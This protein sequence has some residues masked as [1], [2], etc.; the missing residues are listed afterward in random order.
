MSEP[1]DHNERAQQA[2]DLAAAMM[3]TAQARFPEGT[4]GC[5]LLD[6]F[7]SLV[8]T[9]IVPLQRHER[10]WFLMHLGRNVGRICHHHDK[11]IA[12]VINVNKGLH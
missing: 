5:V 6:A 9:A 7:S 1:N 4:P 12:E 2:E 11:G 3:R 10:E 8:A